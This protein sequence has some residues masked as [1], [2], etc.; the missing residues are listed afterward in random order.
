MK[1]RLL[2]YSLKGCGH[3]NNLKEKLNNLKIEYVNKD[4]DIYSNE[5]D[6]VC[7]LLGTDFIPIV[8]IENTWLV[9]EKDFNTIDECVEKIKNLISI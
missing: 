6:R 1:K 9:P 4:I 7:E 8:K 3:C 2:I 5:Y